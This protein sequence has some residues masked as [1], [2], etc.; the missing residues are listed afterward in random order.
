[1]VTTP[2]HKLNFLQP[3]DGYYNPNEHTHTKGEAWR[4]IFF[5]YLAI[6]AGEMILDFQALLYFHVIQAGLESQGGHG[7]L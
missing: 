6:Q 3:V 2:E 5:T 4:R 1:M 7:P